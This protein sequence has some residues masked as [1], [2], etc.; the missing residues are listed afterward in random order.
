MIKINNPILSISESI[1][2]RSETGILKKV[3]MHRPDYGIE[4]VT[5]GNAIELLYED[6]V[7]LPKMM[8]EH[9]QF[10]E[11]LSFFLGEENVVEFSDVL[12]EVLK[13][14]LAKNELLKEICQYENIDQQLKNELLEFSPEVLA[15]ILISGTHSST[16]KTYFKP[17]PNLIFTRDIG[18]AIG[19]YILVSKA[20]KDARK[21]ESILSKYVFMHLSEYKESQLIKIPEKK[22]FSIEGGDIMMLEPDHLLI[23]SSERTTDLALDYLTNLVIDKKIVK[24]VSR[25]ALP[26]LRYCMH[27]DTIFTKVDSA[28]YAGFGPLVTNP[29]VMPVLSKT[30]VGKEEFPS[31]AAML[32]HE[33]PNTQIILSGGGNSPYAEREQ[34]TDGCNLFTVRDG[35]AFTYDRNY[36]TNIAFQK[37]G[38]RLIEASELIH[39]FRKGETLPNQVQQTII[40]IPSSELSRARGGPHC[41]TMP[42]IRE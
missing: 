19:T 27:L 15:S 16:Y 14:D 32:I 1:G 35:V 40:T 11:A 8:E 20:A 33:K 9:D 12:V 10:T 3:L 26:K 6:I 24:K 23:A 13:K 21:R 29:D 7:F 5:P 36:H 25:V 30:L 17:L 28:L 2:V 42:L 38:Y 31:L 18:V 34:W 22:G 4:R 37:A 41:L 39:Q